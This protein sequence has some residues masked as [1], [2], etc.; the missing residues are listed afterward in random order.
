MANDN[1]TD[2]SGKRYF[3][4]GIV[5]IDK[6]REG[7]YI[8]VTPIEKLAMKEGRLKDAG[9][10]LEVSSP[11]IQ[12]TITSDVVKSQTTIK[13]KWLVGDDGNRQTAPDVCEGETVDLYR[14]GNNNEYYWTTTFREPSIRRLETVTYCYGNL[15]SKGAAWNKDSSYWWEVSTH[16][17][18]IRFKTTQ[19]DGE[20]YG[21]DFHISS[22]E[23]T[24]TLEDNIQN[25]WFMDSKE[26]LMRC[27]NADG[28]FVDIEKFKYHGFAKEHMTHESDVIHMKTPLFTVC[29]GEEGSYHSGPFIQVSSQGKYAKFGSGEEAYAHFTDGDISVKSSSSISEETSSK[30]VKNA[31]SSTESGTA[32]EKFGSLSRTADSVTESSGS[33]NRTSESSTETAGAREVKSETSTETHGT[34]AETIGEL[35]QEVKQ[36]QSKVDNFELES[37]TQAIKSDSRTEEYTKLDSTVGEKIETLTTLEQKIVSKA[38]I[39]A[40]E[41]ELTV[42]ADINLRA[43]G[44]VRTSDAEISNLTVPGTIT[45]AGEDVK[46]NT[47]KLFATTENHEGRIGNVEDKLGVHDT[48]FENHQN[49]IKENKDYSDNIKEDLGKSNQAA[50]ELDSRVQITEEEI[51][52]AKD[53]IQSLE[54]WRDWAIK[55]FQLLHKEIEELKVKLE[56]VAQAAAEAAAAAAAAQ[57]SANNAGLLAQAAS[58]TADAASG[59]A[60]AVGEAVAAAAAPAPAPD[61]APAP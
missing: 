60:A 24:I 61:P 18:H 2:Q 29:E 11:D 43:G 54:D 6:P 34:K 58:D 57:Q 10:T 15:A 33:S 31:T 56:E 53:R 14:Y 8:M 45:L 16:D 25:Q 28:S 5:A 40:A 1:P 22:K 26:H 55:E 7:D 51:V 44:T 27:R 46:G 13:A 23:S 17:K 20:A 37:K 35:S 42:D 47:D 59:A 41:Y 52:K 32:T 49:Q 21:Y 19:S 36:Q 3:G 39:S 4:I 48:T 12:G 9:R 50:G 30:S 38:N